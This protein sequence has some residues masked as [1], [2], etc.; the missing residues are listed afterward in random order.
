M[1]YDKKLSNLREDLENAKSLKYRAEAR[2]E[3]LKKQE[4]DIVE[5]LKE[6]GVKPEDLDGEINKLTLEINKLFE[7]ADELLPKDIL[8]KK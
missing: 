5:E 7:E 1:N 6:L 2:L 4:E 8:E 3:Q